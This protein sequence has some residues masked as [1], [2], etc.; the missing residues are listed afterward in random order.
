[1]SSRCF[2]RKDPPSEEE[3]D[4]FFATIAATDG[5]ADYK[6]VRPLFACFIIEIVAVDI[7]I[8]LE[9]EAC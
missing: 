8:R 3:C 5:Y 1:M 9:S 6:N 4:R 2:R 7:R